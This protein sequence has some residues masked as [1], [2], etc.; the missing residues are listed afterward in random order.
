MA[1]SFLNS[2]TKIVAGI[3]DIQSVTYAARSSGAANADSYDTGVGF[4]ARHG[5]IYSGDVEGF[6]R[7]YTTWF[8]YAIAGQ[9]VIPERMG[10]ITDASNVVWHVVT[11]NTSFGGLHHIVDCVQAVS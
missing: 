6:S 5:P 4:S 10:K 11:S 8:L 9:S 7:R 2:L 3:P 1:I